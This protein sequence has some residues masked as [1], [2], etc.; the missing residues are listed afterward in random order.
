MDEAAAVRA[1]PM[2]TIF[3][4]IVCHHF[5]ASTLLTDDCQ[6]LYGPFAS[7]EECQ[8]RKDK[9]GIATVTHQPDADVIVTCMQKTVS[10]WQPV[11]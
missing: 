2:T 5:A 9:L 3:A 8:A 6:V 4:M 7:Y 11:E 1:K 10:T